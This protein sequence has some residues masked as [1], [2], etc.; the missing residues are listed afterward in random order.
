MSRSA[1][2]LWPGL[3]IITIK[4]GKLLQAVQSHRNRPTLVIKARKS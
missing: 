3:V 4:R 1:K 2:L